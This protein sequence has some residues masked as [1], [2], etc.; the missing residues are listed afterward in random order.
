[1]KVRVALT[2][3]VDAAVWATDNGLTDADGRFTSEQVRA[4]VHSYVLN[5]VQSGA[6]IGENTAEVTDFDEYSFGDMTA[7][8]R[9]DPTHPY[10]F[11][12]QLEDEVRPGQTTEQVEQLIEQGRDYA[13]RLDA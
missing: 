5:L 1:M 10:R 11:V 13:S 7:M 4:D 6:A 2:I 8:V 12:T 9:Q 3:D